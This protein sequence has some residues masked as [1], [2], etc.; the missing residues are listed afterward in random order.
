[1]TIAATILVLLTACYATLCGLLMKEVKQ[2]RERQQR[3]QG[4]Q[5]KQDLWERRLVIYNRVLDFLRDFG[6]DTYEENCGRTSRLRV[7]TASAQFLFQPEVSEQIAAIIYRARE[8]CDGKR[9]LLSE[10]PQG[11]P[12]RPEVERRLGEIHAW[13]HDDAFK[14]AKSAF[15]PYLNLCE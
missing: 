2:A 9:C 4:Q 15:S 5:L 8:W 11:D 10:L 1:M 7:D 12:R 6:S 13:M 14:L 3:L